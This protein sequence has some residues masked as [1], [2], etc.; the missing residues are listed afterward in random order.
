MSP[1]RF[2]QPSQVNLN[3]MLCPAILDPFEGANFRLFAVVHQSMLCPLL[4]KLTSH[5]CVWRRGR[6][7]DASEAIVDDDAG[8]RPKSIDSGDRAA[9]APQHNASKQTCDKTAPTAATNIIHRNQAISTG[10]TTSTKAE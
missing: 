7:D 5:F 4:C 8:G 9:A 2:A 1:V 3:H 6:R 10:A